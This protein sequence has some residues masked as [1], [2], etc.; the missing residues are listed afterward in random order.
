MSNFKIFLEKDDKWIELGI[1]SAESSEEAIENALNSNAILNYYTYE[2][3]KFVN[4]EY[5]EVT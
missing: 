2:E 1:F 5:Q 4:L 3:L